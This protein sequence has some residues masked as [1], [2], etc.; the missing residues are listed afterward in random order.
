MGKVLLATVWKNEPIMKNIAEYDIEKLILVHEEEKLADKGDWDQKSQ[1]ISEIEES[2]ISDVIEIKKISTGLNEL[3]RVAKDVYKEI[4]DEKRDII[5]NIAGGRKMQAI[6]TLLA[7]SK[8]KNVEEA[9]YWPEEASKVNEKIQVPLFNF[10]ISEKE[11]KV[12]EKVSRH[13]QAKKIVEDL[14]MSQSM[15]YSHLRELEKKGFLAKED[16][17][18]LTDLG[19]FMAYEPEEDQ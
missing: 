1:E 5:V 19:E 16:G 9:L 14:E 8:T 2:P 13:N 12:I 18:T 15:V 17:W 10:L 4:S 7:A 3:Y 11:Q 6:G